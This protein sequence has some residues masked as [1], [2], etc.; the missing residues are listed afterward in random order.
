VARSLLANTDY[1]LQLVM[2]GA[3]ISLLVGGS[4]IRSWGFNSAVVDGGFGLI[5]RGG[6][7]SFD[8]VRIRTNDRAF[9][10]PAGSL[11]AET[12]SAGT[13]SAPPLE[14]SAL[15]PFVADAKSAWIESGADTSAFDGVRVAVADLSGTQLGQAVGTTIYI[16]IDAA[17]LGW[18]AGGV[19]LFEVIE[20]ELGHVL[21]YA[22]SDGDEHSIM[23]ATL[24]AFAAP[25]LTTIAALAPQQ[26]PLAPN[27]PATVSLI[28]QATYPGDQLSLATPAASR[29]SVVALSTAQTT[30]PVVPL[31]SLLLRG[32]APA[33]ASLLGLMA[34]GRVQGFDTYLSD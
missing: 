4:F 10:A 33:H 24:P 30:A 29:A 15:V 14:E 13:Q 1:Q 12:E 23:H 18:G 34:G 16:D 19:D 26:A 2:K 27:S 9:A 3:S 22:H 7:S 20:H 6:A 5:T 17:G 8:N 11:N 32:L 28:A 31:K 25:S 21:G